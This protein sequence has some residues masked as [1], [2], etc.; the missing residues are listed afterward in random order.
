MK[1]LLLII[2]LCL[3]NFCFSQTEAQRRQNAEY[4]RLSQAT[5]RAFAVPDRPATISSYKSNS[6][7]SSSSYSNS[8]SNQSN[9]SNLYSTQ[10]DNYSWAMTGQYE[11][12]QRQI[13]ATDAKTKKLNDAFD[14]KVAT[15]ENCY[16]KFTKNKEN[17]QQIFN[18]A[19]SSGIDY[20]TACRLIG[21]SADDMQSKIDLVNAANE[22]KSPSLFEGSTKSDCSGNCT[23]TLYYKDR[24]GTYVGNTIGNRPH[25]K[26]ILTLSNGD[27]LTGNFV[28]GNLVGEIVY[29]F[30]DGNRYEGNFYRAEFTGEGKFIF[31]NGDID[32]GTFLHNKLNGFG[33]LKTRDKTISGIFKD[34]NLINKGKKS[35][36]YAN[37]TKYILDYDN[38]TQSSINW[39]NGAFFKGIIDDNFKYV[40]GLL[41]YGNGD[42]FDGEFDT[43]G[44]Y[45][46][47][48]RKYTDGST[49]E[50]TFVNNQ[51]RKGI[52]INS[53]YVFKGIFDNNGENFMVGSYQAMDKTINFEG[54]FGLANSK[55]GYRIDYTPT[56]GIN[57]TIYEDE[58]SI[59]P[60]RFTNKN[61][62]V[63]VGT[64]LNPNYT[65]YGMLR[66]KSGAF[67]PAALIKGEW[68]VLPETER[69]NA[70]KVATETALILQ[71][72]RAEYE[73]AIK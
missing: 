32:Q 63:L 41:N 27:K 51:K 25:G 10:N 71:K 49:F 59:G 14:A 64:N 31:T 58:V 30:I 1:K 22:I 2:V 6:S 45:I 21:F 35:Y 72:A 7:S 37:G 20:Y 17:Y 69:E 26:G 4:S 33:T 36:E 13:A 16:K 5:Q 43:K 65:L 48:K 28:N 55:N 19:T 57:E 46:N 8:S 56:G 40:K 50:G 60:V 52:F 61:N 3:S 70:M 68:I 23:E 54:F 39:S 67:Y 9:N 66:E 18:C 38:P 12:Q 15:V 47:G 29:N 11:R 73:N 24:S 53:K 44:N 42:S 62:N 34:G